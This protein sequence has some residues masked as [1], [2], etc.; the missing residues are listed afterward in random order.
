MLSIQLISSWFLGGKLYTQNMMITLLSFI[1]FTVIGIDIDTTPALLIFVYQCPPF[2][3]RTENM[4]GF[5]S[6][7]NIC[8][9]FFYKAFILIKDSPEVVL[10]CYCR[11]FD[12]LPT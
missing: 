9:C 3:F 7:I 10:V 11:E 5:Y 8:C 2:F 12:R 4:F 1:I 6:E